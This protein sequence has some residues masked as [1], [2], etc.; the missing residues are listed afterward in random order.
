MFSCNCTLYLTNPD[1]CKNCKNSSSSPSTTFFNDSIYTIF[2]GLKYYTGY[3]QYNPETHELVE[4]KD[5][6]IKRLKDELSSNEETIKLIDEQ[7]LS[8][9]K[10][11]SDLIAKNNEIKEELKSLE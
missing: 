11:K 10:Q 7:I 5:S 6:K 4:K 3:E 2:C 8:F 9:S 1:A